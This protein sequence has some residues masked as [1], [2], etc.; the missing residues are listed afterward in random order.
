MDVLLDPV[1]LLALLT[2]TVLEIVL[3]IDNVVFIAIITDSLPPERRNLARRLGLGLALFG[4][5]AMVLGVSWLLTLEHPLFTVLDHEITISGLILVG[6]GLFLLYKAVREIFN[7][8]ELHDEE[9]SVVQ[10]R[11]SLTGVIAQILL[12]DMIFAIDSVLTAV[13]MTDEVLLIIVAIT[14]AIGVMMFFA[15]PVANFIGRHGSVKLLALAFLVLIGVMLILEG[16]GEPIERTTV[17]VAIVF[18]LGVEY[19]NF[20]RRRNLQRR[21]GEQGVIPGQEGL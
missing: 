6:G 20:R 16:V 8:T 4:R 17:Y 5:V 12:I 11:V 2:L 10:R 3:G 21:R 7:T 15:T 9:R 18:A 13:G 19:L 14:I 1:N